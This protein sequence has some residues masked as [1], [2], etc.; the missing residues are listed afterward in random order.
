[1]HLITDEY[2]ELANCTRIYMMVRGQIVQEFQ[3]VPSET[4][5]AS[6][7]EGGY[8]SELMRSRTLA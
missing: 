4:E 1:M 7:V 2:D 3:G 8:L 5:L 6:A